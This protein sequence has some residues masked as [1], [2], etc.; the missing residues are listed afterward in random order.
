MAPF[1]DDPYPHYARLRDED[2]V[3]LTARGVWWLTRYDDVALA[4]R[5]PRFGRAG[6]ARL[7]SSSDPAIAGSLLFQDPPD[8]TRLRGL[9]GKAFAPFMGP[10]LRERVQRIADCLIDGLQ[11]VRTVD[12]IAEFALPL[13]VCVICDILGVP[14]ADRELLRGW[15]LEIALGLDAAS[16]GSAAAYG[17]IGGYLQHLIAERR[18]L[19]QADLLTSLIAVEERGDHLTDFELV[20]VCAL[21]FVA[22][23]QNSMNLIG[24]GMLT[25]LRHPDQ[26][27]QLRDDAMLLPCAIEELLRY[28]S[29]AQRA[30]RIMNAQVQIG[31]KTIRKGAVVLAISGS[32]NRDERQFLGADRLDITRRENRHLAFGAGPR[33]CLGAA[34]ARIEGQIAIGSLLRRMPNLQLTGGAPVWRKSTEFRALSELWVTA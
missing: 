17:A 20:D 34:L 27:R 13:P 16:A 23:H 18:K 33:F 28:E 15:S 1:P 29:P 4:L 22:G 6:F 9:V 8:H 10:G 21:L 30:G 19:P 12:L 2:P 11:D 24:N 32:A 14:V 25:L 31:G 5:D 7:L 26:M 3:H